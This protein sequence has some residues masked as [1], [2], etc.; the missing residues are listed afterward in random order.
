MQNSVL[1]ETCRPSSG[2]CKSVQITSLPFTLTLTLDSPGPVDGSVLTE[3]PQRRVQQRHIDLTVRQHSHKLCLPL[4]LVPAKQEV[5]LLEK[6][7][8]TRRNLGQCNET[9]KLQHAVMVGQRGSL[10][11]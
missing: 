8:Q 6:A 10:A 9:L 2:L 1:S 11:A 5:V 4:G 7:S 3:R